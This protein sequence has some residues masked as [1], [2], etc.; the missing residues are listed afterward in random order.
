MRSLRRGADGCGPAGIRQVSRI[1][2]M[3]LEAARALDGARR[4]PVGEPRRVVLGR[5]ARCPWGISPDRPNLS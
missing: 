4:R 3:S 5:R 2:G 1:R